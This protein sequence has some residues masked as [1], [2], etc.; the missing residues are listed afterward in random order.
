MGMNTDIAWTI[1]Y[2]LKPVIVN[3]QTISRAGETDNIAN[4]TVYRGP[5]ESSFMNGVYI[6]N[7]VDF[8][9]A[10]RYAET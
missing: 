2:N 3:M 8:I 6:V 1:I 7:D 9:L 10:R 4:A 5:T